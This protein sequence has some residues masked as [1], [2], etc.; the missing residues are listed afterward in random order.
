MSDDNLKMD[1]DALDGLTAQLNSLI[2]DG[3]ATMFPASFHGEM[4][5]GGVENAISDMASTDMSSTVDHGSAYANLVATSQQIIDEQHR[6]GAKAQDAAAAQRAAIVN[7][8]Q[9]S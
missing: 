9:T 6:S 8:L 4:G 2:R 1:A 5:D 7:A 3:S